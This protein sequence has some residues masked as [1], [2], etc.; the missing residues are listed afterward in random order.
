MAVNYILGVDPGE[1]TGICLLCTM[2]GKLTDAYD[3]VQCNLDAALEVISGLTRDIGRTK[4]LWA[5]EDFVVGARAGR[6]SSAN[7]GA[8]TRGLIGQMS[9]MAEL[10]GV[11]LVKR[12]ASNVKPWATNERLKAAGVKGV[13]GHSLDGARHALF[14]AVKAGYCRDP[15]SKKA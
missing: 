10:A 13:G 4:Q 14:A 8:R 12:S 5:T 9:A 6:S 7:A 3:I 1:T 11:T 2:D 15:L